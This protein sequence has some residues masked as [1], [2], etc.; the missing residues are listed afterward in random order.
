MK[1]SENHIDKIF[2]DNLANQSFD[3]PTEFIDSLNDQLDKIE[4]RKN[5]ISRTA[6]YFINILFLVIFTL[7]SLNLNSSIKQSAQH[8][9]KT[10]STI[11]HSNSLAERKKLNKK[12]SFKE[13]K[14]AFKVKDK[15]IL[16][17][18][19]DKLESADQSQKIEIKNINN[20]KFFQDNSGDFATTRRNRNIFKQGNTSKNRLKAKENAPLNFYKSSD[21]E[22]LSSFENEMENDLL[23]RDRNINAKNESVSSNYIAK[24]EKENHLP[25]DTIFVRDTIII[26]DT[27]TIK[28]TVIVMD[29]I[30][31]KD[32]MN[33][34]LDNPNKWNFEVQLFAG[35]NLGSQQFSKNT[36]SNSSYLLDERSIL[37]PAFG[38]NIN[39][40]R[41]KL[42]I[43]SGLEYFQTGE[44]LSLNSNEIF[45]SDSVKIVD[46]VFDSVVYDSTTQSFDT[47]Y[48]PVYDTVSYADTITKSENWMNTYSW[49]SV[50]LNFGY[51][52][53][54]GKWA[55]IPKAGVT[56][57]IGLRNSDG[58]YYNG[59]GNNIG[60]LKSKPVVFN[61][62]YLLQLEIRRSIGKA[63]I[64]LSPNYRGNI[65]PM[66]PGFTT[67]KYKSLGARFGVV[68]KF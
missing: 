58:Q 33:L 14:N 61:L 47:I 62:D 11:K 37:T 49:L 51:R 3:I 1:N 39:A 17:N 25:P 41:N 18:N 46:Y 50:P 36:T 54:I 12:E 28:D 22:E 63:E 27:L 52:Y 30:L 2:R 38:F 40:T 42:S 26:Y 10:K 19:N 16:E 7:L 60:I 21:P 66:I 44:K 13:V 9:S 59:L 6:Y 31:V 56:F 64:Y 23:K 43:G 35:M 68:L 20:S 67:R 57:N 65:T 24:D 55:I 34:K 5:S 4:P 15:S 53:E 32:T 29:T 48:V 8:D 45:Q